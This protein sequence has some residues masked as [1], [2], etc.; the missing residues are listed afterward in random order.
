MTNGFTK[1]LMWHVDMPKKIHLSTYVLTARKA[2]ATSHVLIVNAYGIVGKT[3]GCSISL[4][5]RGIV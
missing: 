2:N 3:V 1:I 4:S 5:M